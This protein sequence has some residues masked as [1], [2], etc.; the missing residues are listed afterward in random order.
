MSSEGGES[1]RFHLIYEDP[2]PF[3]YFACSA[4]RA[5]TTAWPFHLAN[6]AQP[7]GGYEPLNALQK[8]VLRDF[9]RYPLQL[10]PK[11]A[12]LWTRSALALMVFAGL[13]CEVRRF[14]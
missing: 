2:D 3:K 7:S 1:T 14:F 10:D 12:N 11:D 13:A 4:A 5:H 6:Y 8:Q 9:A